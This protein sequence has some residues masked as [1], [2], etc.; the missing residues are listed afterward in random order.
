MND[1]TCYDLIFGGEIYKPLSDQ[2]KQYEDQEFESG[3]VVIMNDRNGT[4]L[5]I[6]CPIKYS[7]INFFSLFL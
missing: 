1:K 6:S 3:G 5:K 2:S 7:Y 4:Y